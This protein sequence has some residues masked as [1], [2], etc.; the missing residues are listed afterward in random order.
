MTPKEF[1][2]Y[3]K[4][5]PGEL[6]DLLHAHPTTISRWLNDSQEPD[7]R[8]SQAIKVI[9]LR[10]LEWNLQEE[11]LPPIQREL[12]EIARSRRANSADTHEAH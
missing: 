3:W 5:R 4:L 11:L 1:V 7:S 2:D 12:Y 10:W 8:T 9:H 6:A